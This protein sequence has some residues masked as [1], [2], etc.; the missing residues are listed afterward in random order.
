MITDDQFQGLLIKIIDPSDSESRLIR[1][2]E[3]P[4]DTAVFSSRQ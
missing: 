1:L 3:P 4:L 2:R